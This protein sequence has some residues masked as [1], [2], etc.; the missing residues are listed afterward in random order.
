MQSEARPKVKIEYSSG[1]GDCECCGSYSWE[2]AIVTL[3]GREVLNHTGDTHLGGGV[4]VEW[5]ESLSAIL[6]A[7]GFDIEIEEDCTH[8]E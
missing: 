3:N 2:K 1:W 4:W 7:L 8:A 5:S 6:P